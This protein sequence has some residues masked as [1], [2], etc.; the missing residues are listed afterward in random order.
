MAFDAHLPTHTW[1]NGIEQRVRK[2]LE[3]AMFVN[4]KSKA[5]ARLLEILQLPMP[6]SMKENPVNPSNIRRAEAK[7]ARRLA[8]P[9]VCALLPSLRSAAYG[10]SFARRSQ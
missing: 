8:R 2:R 6:R 5:S 9:S 4:G 7:S 10:V 3:L 1:V